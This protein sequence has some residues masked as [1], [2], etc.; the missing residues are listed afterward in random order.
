MSSARRQKAYSA[1][2]PRRLAAGRS[3]I[4]SVKLEPERDNTA[5]QW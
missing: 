4:G 5:A 3:R 1:V 2:V